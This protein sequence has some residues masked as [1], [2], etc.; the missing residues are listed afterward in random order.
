M[1]KETYNKFKAIIKGVSDDTTKDLLPNLQKS[2]EYCTEIWLA[3][4]MTAQKVHLKTSL[5]PNQSRR[6]MSMPF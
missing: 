4:S 3:R 6:N 2:L 1:I 5:D